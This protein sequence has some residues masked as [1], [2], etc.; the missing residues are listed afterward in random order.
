[1]SRSTPAIPRHRTAARPGLFSR[2]G[3]FRLKP[4]DSSEEETTGGLR[5]TMGLWQLVALS[6]GGLVGAGVFSLA[7]VVAHEDA[8]PG[9]LISFLVAII[10]S[11]A[12]ALCYAEF[13]GTIPKAGS[14][15]T[16][17]YAALGEIV[18][19]AIGWDLL[20]EYTAIVAV[21]AIAVSG[22]LSYI[23]QHLGID[24]P[25][26]M[27]GAPGTGSGHRV[28]L[29]AALL[30]VL[31]AFVLSRGTK[32]SARFETVLV[33]VKLAIVALVIVAGAFH[34]SAGN[35]SPFLPFGI[36][37][38][39]TGA[40][41]T[42]FAV[43]GY[44][45]MSAAAEES[46]EAKKVLPKAIVISLAIAAVIYLL[47]CLVLLGMQNYRDIDV[48][49][50][51]SS[52][53]AAVGL[54]GLGMVV[55]VGAV[56]GITTS[57][58]A[59]MLAVTRVWFSMSRDGLLPRSFARNHPTRHV[60]TRVIWPVGIGSALIAGFLPIREAAD[61]TNIGIL[62]AFV[63]VA[64]AVV[65]MRRTRP[66]LP[67]AFRTPL[68]PFVPA[69]GVAFSIWLISNLDRVT[70]VRFAVWMVLGLIVYGLFG[71]RNSAEHRGDGHAP[72]ATP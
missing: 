59:N 39:F 45:A 7:G 1:M 13:A 16:Y 28:D 63:V 30:C 18:G 61:L 26:W 55:A 51:F 6:L 65:V 54:G 64:V 47:V 57:A 69:V 53:L 8:G 34:I 27:L 9:V 48:K 68:V 5:R 37:G 32:E 23:L 33:A 35:Y 29:L 31:L 40:A 3:I 15:Y 62:M 36:G 50:P 56:I 58:F 25:N 42:F 19:W 66:D 10:A 72:G 4:V 43:Y 67:R 71:Y 22:Y 21:V 2:E 46:A 24:L 49:S 44:D 52:A 17:S 60:P 12:A 38:A 14:A 11:A 41:T 20:L 70:W